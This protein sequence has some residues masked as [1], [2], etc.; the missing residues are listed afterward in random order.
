LK[1]I[2]Y[3]DASAGISGDMFVGALLDLG[4]SLE[5][6]RRDVAA[7]QLD[8]IEL[9]ARRINHRGLSGTKFDVLD[10]RS[11]HAVDASGP[12]RPWLPL[13]HALPALQR[14]DTVRPAP[15]D[16]HHHRGLSEIRSMIHASRL[17]RPIADDA[18]AVFE[19]LAA[20]EAKVHGVSL[21][22][23]HFHEVGALDSIA[24]VVAAAS[25]FH[26]VAPAEAWC[27]AIHVGSG[28]FRCAHGL[29][30]V[31]APAT[32]ELLKGIPAY[33]TD[34]VGE[35]ATPTGVALVRHYCK[36]GTMPPMRVEAV[37]YGGGS[38]DFGMP[39]FV[40]ATLGTAIEAANP[41]EP[42]RAASAR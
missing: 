41:V 9:H 29:M 22:D 7:L 27:S 3:I 16:H 12:L 33:A 37:G 13:R 28:T 17:S 6:V 26:E 30:P 14:L 19:L 24:D 40:R 32:L 23:V 8:G 5:R 31:P 10:P 25:A 42:G 11:G 35:L 18:V 21:E 36:F 4:V 39:N 38:K 15:R 34:I 20:A 1:K 2:L